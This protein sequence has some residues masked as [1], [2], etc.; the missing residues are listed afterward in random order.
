MRLVFGGFFLGLD[1]VPVAA[2]ARIPANAPLDSRRCAVPPAG[3]REPGRRAMGWG[4]G[5][6]HNWVHSANLD[7][8]FFHVGRFQG[9]RFWIVFVLRSQNRKRPVFPTLDMHPPH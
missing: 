9:S 6:L 2:C 8:Q 7:F 4:T 3:E 5:L 1:S